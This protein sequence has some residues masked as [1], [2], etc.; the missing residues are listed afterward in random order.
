MRCEALWFSS[1][2]VCFLL[3]FGELRLGVYLHGDQS[4]GSALLDVV[5]SK[6]EVFGIIYK[7]ALV[8]EDGRSAR[9]E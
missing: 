1:P 2:S 8:K 7:V 9:V 3:T 6:C 5:V 4:K